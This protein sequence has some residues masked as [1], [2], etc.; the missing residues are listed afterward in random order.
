M[1]R[2]IQRGS[3]ADSPSAGLARSWGTGLREENED[4][5]RPSSWSRSST[6]SDRVSALRCARPATHAGSRTQARDDF[7]STTWTVLKWSQ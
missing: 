1:V 5:M 2:D 3:D 6:C 4:L 7:A